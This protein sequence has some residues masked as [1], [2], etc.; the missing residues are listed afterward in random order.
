MVK[1]A[2]KVALVLAAA[3]ESGGALSYERLVIRNLGRLGVSRPEF[4]L[5]SISKK[6]RRRA[7][8]SSSEIHLKISR[9]HEIGSFLRSNILGWRMLQAVGLKRS[10]L[11]RFLISN[12]V[13]LVF[14]LSP[15][16]LALGVRNVPMVT[17]VWDL[18]H[19]DLP[20]FPE[21]SGGSYFLDREY[22][23]RDT[24]ARS[25]LVVVDSADT[26]L[27]LSAIYGLFS[28]RAFVLP[29]SALLA[30]Q[31]ILPS[32]DVRHSPPQESRPRLI[33]P[34]QFWPHKR[35]LLLLRAFALVLAEFPSALLFLT[36]SEKGNMGRVLN[37]IKKLG[38]DR[39]VVLCGFLDRSDLNQLMESCDLL[40][41]PSELGPT[42]LPPHE[43]QQLGIPSLVSPSHTLEKCSGTIGRVSHQD[44]VS[45]ASEICRLLRTDSR[46]LFSEP[47]DQAAFLESRM[48]ALV[49]RFNAILELEDEWGGPS[50]K[51]RRVD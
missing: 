9:R 14:F 20:E 2:P 17:T 44:P 31:K 49:S 21:F 40:V 23:F 18:A 29:F 46:D 19:R 5:I 22:F 33:Y 51:Y 45:W 50:E 13:D 34:A 36:G 12:R 41:F 42:N 8:C 48:T 11:E 6:T 10:K 24:V 47:N 35:H 38:L 43:A 3:T 16:I 32:R 30:V 4:V 26:A 1:S 37:E 7:E 28:E 39:S 25:S 27:K 15:N